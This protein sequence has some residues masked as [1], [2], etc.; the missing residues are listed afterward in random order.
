MVEYVVGFIEN[1]DNELGKCELND[2]HADKLIATLS[3][4]Q[5]SDPTFQAIPGEEL[6]TAQL[7]DSF[8]SE[9]RD[10]LPGR[11]VLAIGFDDERVSI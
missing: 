8:C 3:D 10:R 4:T 11:E 5:P 6:L 9:V 1:E 7:S 2:Y